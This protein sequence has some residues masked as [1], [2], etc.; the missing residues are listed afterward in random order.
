[1]K[2]MKPVSVARASYFERHH[3]DYTNVHLAIPSGAAYCGL[4]S[5]VVEQA[6]G[7]RLRYTCCI[8]CRRGI[9][10]HSPRAAR[11]ATRWRGRP[12]SSVA[13]D[14]THE[15]MHQSRMVREWIK[16]ARKMVAE[17]K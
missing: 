7:R 1:M 11:C 2:T 6:L 4:L 8:P 9:R 13:I 14:Y 5:A 15:K 10:D 3:A 12:A 17:L 16:V